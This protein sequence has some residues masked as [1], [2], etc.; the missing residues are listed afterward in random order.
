MR[1]SRHR[2]DFRGPSP[3]RA[4]AAP[5]GRPARV[6]NRRRCADHRR[7]PGPLR[8]GSGDRA[9]APAVRSITQ[10]VTP[11]VR[12]VAGTAATAVGDTATGRGGSSPP[13][14]DG[15]PA[16]PPPSGP[17]FVRAR[18]IRR[19]GGASHSNPDAPPAGL[20]RGV[21]PEAAGRTPSWHLSGALIH[22]HGVAKCQRLD[23]DPGAGE[24][25]CL[26]AV[27]TRQRR[28]PQM[29]GVCRPFY[30]ALYDYV[31]AGGDG[32]F[33]IMKDCVGSDPKKVS[34]SWPIYPK[35]V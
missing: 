5:P 9:V 15:P 2:P 14:P 12:A 8:C 26:K 24:T 30:P 28:P 19:Y 35:G 17:R 22:R 6:D 13:R 10:Q 16:P 11:A 29:W 18:R 3:R 20:L 34:R 7:N 23:A 1:D 4:G 32:M 27:R 33:M 31:P 21:R 25:C